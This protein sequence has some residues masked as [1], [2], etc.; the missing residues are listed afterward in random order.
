MK[1]TIKDVARAAGVSVAT[2]SMALNDRVG[3][4]EKTRSRVKQVASE[5]HYIPDYMARGLVTQ[6]S[7]CIGLMVPELKNPF[8]SAVVDAFSHIAEQKGFT[9]LLGI[10]GSR[11]QQ[12]QR[13]LE[14]FLAR[15]VVGVVIVPMLTDRPDVSYLD[16]LRRADVPLVFLTDTYAGATEPVVMCDFAQGQYQVT[17]LLLDKGVRDLY[18][19]TVDMDT[20]FVNRRMEGYLRAL[21]EAGL[22]LNEKRVL[23]LP[24]SSYDAAYQ[25]ADQIFED[26]PQA[27]V[28]INDIM[29][30]G[31]MKK[32]SERGAQ[33]P[34]DLWAVGFDDV[35]VAA[36]V[37][38]QLT[39]VHQPVTQ[40]CRQTFALLEK[41]IAAGDDQGSVGKGEVILAQPHLVQRESSR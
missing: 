25:A 26:L 37:T 27:V 3:V 1:R 6:D 12:E 11:P 34:R 2:A 38:P 35:L 33:V 15:R 18:Y 36:L 14:M 24:T 17:R 13:Y 16:M 31:L 20:N 32:L 7:N 22:P 9:L 4:S 39:T 40:M 29:T 30:I 10:S 21:D 8:Y 23:R 41:K 5:L 28:C 19:V